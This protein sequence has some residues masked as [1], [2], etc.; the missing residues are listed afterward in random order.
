MARLLALRGP[1]SPARCGQRAQ[2]QLREGCAWQCCPDG[3]S[4]I[5]AGPTMRRRSSI[6]AQSSRPPRAWD[7]PAHSHWARKRC[8]VPSPTPM[9]TECKDQGHP[10]EHEIHCKSATRRRQVSD[11]MTSGSLYEL[12]VLV[13]C[14][15]LCWIEALII[16]ATAV[17]GLSPYYSVDAYFVRL[18]L[19]PNPAACSD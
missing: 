16:W 15:A 4:I 13:K 5:A 18:G 11:L 9:P 10:D 19:S 7:G 14:D 6:C 12:A 1:S 17:A 2:G 8:H 3:L